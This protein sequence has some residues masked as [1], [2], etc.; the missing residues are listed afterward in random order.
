VPLAH[1]EQCVKD[2]IYVQPLL[3]M[4]KVGGK[5]GKGEQTSQMPALDHK[6]PPPFA[7]SLEVCLS[8][9]QSFPLAPVALP[10]KAETNEWV[11]EEHQVGRFR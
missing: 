11:V 10:G 5:G 2:L 3:K 4:K 9:S 1:V 8:P 7:F 6:H